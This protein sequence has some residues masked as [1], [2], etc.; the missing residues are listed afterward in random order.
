MFCEQIP[1]APSSSKLFDLNQEA[2]DLSDHHSYTH[3]IQTTEST[4]T[5][6]EPIYYE[7]LLTKEQE[8]KRKEKN[9]R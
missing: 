5:A 7:F 9:I 4:S 1:F 2:T 8:K 6:E 3:Q